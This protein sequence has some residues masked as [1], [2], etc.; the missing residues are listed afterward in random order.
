MLKIN[1]SITQ[2][3]MLHSWIQL[4]CLC[5]IRNRV[6]SLVKSKPVKKEVS[7]SVMLPLIKRTF[8]T[9]SLTARKNIPIFFC[10][11][12]FLI[13][14]EL[15]AFRLAAAAAATTY[16][17]FESME[18]MKFAQKH[19]S[20]FFLLPQLMQKLIIA[21]TNCFANADLP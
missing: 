8:S 17:M 2:V 4:L 3:T 16:L 12:V 19:L 21:I 13:H 9:L 1:F 11:P 10:F 6:T 20:P 14:A 18:R 5:G 15:T 7:R